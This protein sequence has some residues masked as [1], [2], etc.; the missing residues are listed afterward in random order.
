MVVE[1]D[2]LRKQVQEL[3][4]ESIKSMSLLIQAEQLLAQVRNK[5]M[6]STAQKVDIVAK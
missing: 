6:Q 5:M 3:D 1:G 2:H 4:I